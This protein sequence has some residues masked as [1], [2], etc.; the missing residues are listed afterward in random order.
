MPVGPLTFR[1]VCGGFVTFCELSVK[2]CAG[3]QTEPC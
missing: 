3:V 1:V 2:T